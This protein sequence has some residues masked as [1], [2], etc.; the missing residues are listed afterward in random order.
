MHVNAR[1]WD[2]KRG[3][4]KAKARAM[5]KAGKRPN[6]RSCD[7]CGKKVR[8]GWIHLKCLK[9]EKKI[10][11]PLLELLNRA[12]DNTVPVVPSVAD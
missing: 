2:K 4:T 11:G 5:E 8:K 10:N 12:K 6:N 1:N 9:E 3:I 7:W